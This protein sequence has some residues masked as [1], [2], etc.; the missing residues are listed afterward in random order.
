[1]RIISVVTVRPQFL[2]AATESRA[3]R[4]LSARGFDQILD[5]IN[6]MKVHYRPIPNSIV[7]NDLLKR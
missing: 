4:E 3:I 7:K 2:E 1:M 6:S 5:V